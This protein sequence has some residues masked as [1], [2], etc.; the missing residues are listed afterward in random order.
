MDIL[1]VIKNLENRLWSQYSNPLSNYKK[2]QEDVHMTYY[3]GRLMEELGHKWINPSKNAVDSADCAYYSE[4]A[5]HDAFLAGQLLAR[6]DNKKLRASIISELRTELH[7]A[8]DN[9]ELWYNYI[10][11]VIG[12]SKDKQLVEDI[13]GS[14]SEFARSLEEYGDWFEMDGLY[15]EYDEETDVHTFLEQ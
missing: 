10:M 4:K 9:M 13:F 7:D 14:V 15:V 5:L 11:T 8:I 6:A 12:A 1:E 3:V 2:S